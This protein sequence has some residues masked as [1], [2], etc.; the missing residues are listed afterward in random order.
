MDSQ[1]G[2]TRRALPLADAAKANAFPFAADPVRPAAVRL[3]LSNP[4][5]SPQIGVTT[6]FSGLI[7]ASSGSL[8][9]GV[10]APDARGEPSQHL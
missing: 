8:V 9:P 4:V 6:I 1:H 7:G 3:S 5:R 10:I 2:P